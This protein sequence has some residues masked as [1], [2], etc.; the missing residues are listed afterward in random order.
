MYHIKCSDLTDTNCDYE[1]SG[2][3]KDELKNKY[4]QHGAESDLH[5]EKF[6]TATDEDKANFGKKLGEYL[7]GQE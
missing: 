2:E 3:D 6:A 5:K 7:E 1:A 4:F